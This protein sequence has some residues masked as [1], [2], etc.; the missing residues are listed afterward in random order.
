MKATI[1][2]SIVKTYQAEIEIDPTSADNDGYYDIVD[3]ILD[4]IEEEDNSVVYNGT[5][6]TARIEDEHRV[7]FEIE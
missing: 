2:I 5:Y 4:K 7:Y 1:F 6:T 3:D